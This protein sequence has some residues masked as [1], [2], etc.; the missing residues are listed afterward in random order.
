MS[1]K[2]QTAGML[3]V[4]PWIAVLLLAALIPALFAGK[5]KKQ[6]AE[7]VA[8]GVSF[9]SLQA[10]KDPAEVEKLVRTRAVAQLRSEREDAL[11]SGSI[12]G[13]FRDYVIL[14]DSRAVGFWLFHFLDESRVI[15]DGGNTIR[16]ISAALDTIKALNPAYIY[17]C[18]GV[19]DAGIGYWD[20]GEAYAKEF[21]EHIT[22]LQSA[23]PGVKVIVNSILPAT[24]GAMQASPS[25]RKIPDFNKAVKAMC[26]EKGVTYVDNEEIAAEYMDTMW[27]EDG[28]HLHEE[29]YP[30]W[31]KNLLMGAIE[32]DLG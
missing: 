7:P 4:L 16:D 13:Q 8:E 29:F 21:D 18:Y 11:D 5:P 28:V 26:A 12:W 19:N 3:T 2:R 32:A 31:A 17:L 22:E 24:E 30:I 6:K 10:Q 27:N 14:G 23:V 20:D 15:A 9:L 25:W 1:N